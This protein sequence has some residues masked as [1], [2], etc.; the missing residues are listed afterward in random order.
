MRFRQAAIGTGGGSN[1]R[2]YVQMY[3][4]AHVRS[5]FSPSRG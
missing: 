1:S 5:V 4:H 3:W 2:L